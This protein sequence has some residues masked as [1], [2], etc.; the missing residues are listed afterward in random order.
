MACNKV[1]AA[2]AATALILS[3]LLPSSDARGMCPLFR[4]IVPD[5]HDDAMRCLARCQDQ[6]YVG[7]FCTTE[8]ICMCAQCRLA[9]YYY[10]LGPSPSPSP[11]PE[12]SPEPRAA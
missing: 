1:I 11:S 4:S 12:P 7:G 8:Q 3:F 5:C 6:G 2:A 10:Q 9:D